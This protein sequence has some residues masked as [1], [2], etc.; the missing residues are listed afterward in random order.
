MCDVSAASC[1]VVNMDVDLVA[2]ANSIGRVA[3][4]MSLYVVHRVLYVLFQVLIK[5]SI[6]KTYAFPAIPNDVE[7]TRGH[8]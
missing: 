1:L 4:C 8:Q 7:V 2:H 3:C 6:E 5:R